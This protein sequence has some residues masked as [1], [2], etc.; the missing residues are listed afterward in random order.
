MRL[1]DGDLNIRVRSAL[2]EQINTTINTN[3]T[4]AQWHFLAVSFGAA[5]FVVYLDGQVVFSDPTFTVGWDGNS[6]NLLVGGDNGSDPPGATSSFNNEFDGPVDEIALFD[7][8]LDETTVSELYSLG[9]SD[10]PTGGAGTSQPGNDILDGGDGNDI[11]DGGA[12]ADA[13]DGG[14]GDD[15]LIVDLADLQGGVTIDGGEGFDILK[16]A[17]DDLSL[18]GTLLANVS[19]IEEIDL[20]GDSA[21]ALSLTAGDVLDI[22]GD[23]NTLFVTTEDATALDTL[24][25]EGGFTQTGTSV[26]APQVEGVVKQGTFNEFTANAGTADEVKVYVDPD[27][28]VTTS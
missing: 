16:L 28:D 10:D 7:V 26:S 1:E 18:D 11:L 23:A 21:T 4:A 2:G 8:Q 5:G 13:M 9:I 12:G 3:V 22:T 24:T 25:L 14:D 20:S 6:E 27:V 19:N 15:T 17:D